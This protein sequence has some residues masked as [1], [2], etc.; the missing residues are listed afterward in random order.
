HLSASA[1]ATERPAVTAPTGPKRRQPGSNGYRKGEESRR[2]ILE[3]AL[4]E[5]GRVGY[6]AATTRAIA[7]QAETTLPSLQYYF[8]GKQGLYLACAQ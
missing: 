7:L 5:F 1:P 3:A 4:R 2:R 8:G 6:A